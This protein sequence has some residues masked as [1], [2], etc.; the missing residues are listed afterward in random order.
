MSADADIAATAG[1][2]AKKSRQPEDCRDFFS[3][4]CRPALTDRS[5]GLSSLSF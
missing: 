2:I 1:F 3:C 4:I 5:C